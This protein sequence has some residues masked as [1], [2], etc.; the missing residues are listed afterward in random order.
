MDAWFDD[1]FFIDSKNY[2]NS[3]L[4]IHLKDRKADANAVID[5]TTHTENNKKK[6]K[7]FK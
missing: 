4:C 3:W 2:C 1:I 7:N 6:N 5:K